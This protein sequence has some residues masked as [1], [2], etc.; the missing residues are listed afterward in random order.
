MKSILFISPDIPLASGKGFQVQ[1]FY[2]LEYLSKSYRLHVVCF[3]TSHD[4]MNKDVSYLMS[5]GVTFSF[6]KFNWVK[7]FFKSLKALFFTNLPLQCAMYSSSKL[8]KVIVEYINLN[9]PS[10]IVVNTIR[11]YKNLDSTLGIPLA[12]DI[13]DSMALNFE[14]KLIHSNALIKP[15]INLELKRV[16]KYEKDVAQHADIS[17]VVSEIDKAKINTGNIISIPIGVPSKFISIN[18]SYSNNFDVIFTGN[19]SYEPNIL[20]AQWFIENCWNEVKNA[21]QSSRFFIVGNRPG[22]SILRLHNNKDI[23]VTGR[24]NSVVDKIR[25]CRVAIAPMISGSGMQFKII[26]AMACGVPVVTTEMGRGDIKVKHL[27]HL[28]VANE[29][30]DFIDGIFR[31]FESDELC[32][33]LSQNALDFVKNNHEWNQINHRFERELLKFPSS[34]D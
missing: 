28:F 8:S 19:M 11:V 15:I 26:E 3:E 14:R 5:L 9:S 25:S 21:F 12:V 20:A 7:A 6:I 22:E 32:S 13:L 24:V 27:E 16:T 2:R 23:I 18:S 4:D 33:Q 1:L 31:L 10:F 30:S 17:F 34:I 29:P